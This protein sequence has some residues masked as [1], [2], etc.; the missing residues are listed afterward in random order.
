MH[1]HVYIHTYFVPLLYFISLH[2]PLSFNVIT[3][4]SLWSSAKIHRL[5]ISFGFSELWE[6]KSR[7]Y[8]TFSHFDEKTLNGSRSGNERLKKKEGEKGNEA[9]ALT[10]IFTRKNDLNGMMMR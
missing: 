9:S 8:V 4:S 10:K 3:L 7:C 6:F 2:A 5:H 1:L